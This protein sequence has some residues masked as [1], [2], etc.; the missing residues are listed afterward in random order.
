MHIDNAIWRRAHWWALASVLLAASACGANTETELDSTQQA[1]PGDTYLYLRC[2]ATGWVLNDETRLLPTTD[3]DVSTLTFSVEQPWMVS[4]GDQCIISETNQQ[5]GWGTWQRAFTKA[6]SSWLYVPG[7]GPIEPGWTY[8]NVVYPEL[9]EYTA[10]LDWST[11]TLQIEPSGGTEPLLLDWPLPGEQGEDWV[12]NSYVDL[13]PSSGVVDYQ[14]G[15]RSYDG[16]RGTDWDVSTFREMDAGVPVLAV[17]SGEV[18][19]YADSN[20]DRNLYCTGDWN[21]VSVRA[22]NGYEIIYGHLAQDSVEVN[23][24]QRVEPGDVLGVVGSSGCSTQPHV[25]L[26]IIDQQ[27]NVVDPFVE[28]LWRNPPPYQTPLTVMDI[29]VSD[30]HMSSIGDIIDPVDNVSVFQFGDAIS[31]GLSVA[32]TVPGDVLDVNVLRPDGTVY[33]SAVQTMTEDYPHSFWYWNFSIS[34]LQGPEG[35]YT[36]EVLANQDLQVTYEFDVEAP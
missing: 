31:I 17:S 10:T 20:P 26:E 24:G 13:D 21:F 5:N 19:G 9:G 32:G 29:V 2:N 23:L 30:Q 12:I 14:G 36:I 8:F 11:S 28:G 4:S 15:M 6:D 34:G 22:D 1:L 16:H 35:T 27:G 7:T 33:F 3:P 25:H 18:I